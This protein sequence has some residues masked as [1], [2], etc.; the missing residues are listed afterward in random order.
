MALYETK[1]ASKHVTTNVLLDS[2]V[3]L[4]SDTCVMEGRIAV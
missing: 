2:D 1:K 3:V 4:E